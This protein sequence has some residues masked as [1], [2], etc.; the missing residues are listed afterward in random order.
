MLKNNI[1][2]LKLINYGTRQVTDRAETINTFDLKAINK[3]G[4][5]CA[6]TSYINHVLENNGIRNDIFVNS[7]DMVIAH[8]LKLQSEAEMLFAYLDKEKIRYT[9]FKGYVVRDIYPAFALREMGDLDVYVDKKNLSIADSYLL[10]N[11]FTVHKDLDDYHYAY[12]NNIV[13]IELHYRFNYGGLN[14]YW[15]KFIRNI[16]KRLVNKEGTYRYDMSIEDEYIY[17]F[18]HA[19]RH[20]YSKGLGFRFLLDIFYFLKSYQEKFNWNYINDW[21]SKLELSEFH[22][23]TLELVDLLFVEDFDEN[24]L[25]EKQQTLLEDY[26]SNGA[27]Q[28]ARKDGQIISN[29]KDVA[30]KSWLYIYKYSLKELEKNDKWYAFHAPFA[31]RHRWYRPIALFIISVK[32]VLDDPI[33][34]S[35]RYG[36]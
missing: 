6:M 5:K 36:G 35:I 34:I 32:K 16:E 8:N 27:Y 17:S 20:I 2:F 13:I 33:G 15:N 12:F 3:I 29:L 28:G 25:S 4:K 9:P 24:R 21:I 23:E 18:M 10:E 1:D 26:I 11:S 7:Q 14:R 19:Y 22:D 30:G 31:Y